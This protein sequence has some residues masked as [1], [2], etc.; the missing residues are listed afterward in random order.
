MATSSRYTTTDLRR[1]VGS[2][3]PK[4]RGACA[5]LERTSRRVSNLATNSPSKKIKKHSVETSSSM[6]TAD[7]K[8]KAVPSATTRIKIIQTICECQFMPSKSSHSLVLPLHLLDLEVFAQSGTVFHQFDS[9]TQPSCF[10][11][12]LSGTS[13]CARGNMTWGL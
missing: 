1:Q 9:S 13:L 3:R 10:L 5:I 4:G 12:G 2:P 11:V 7:T 8:T 6:V